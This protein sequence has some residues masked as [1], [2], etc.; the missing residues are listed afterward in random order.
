M[1]VTLPTAFSDPRSKT[2]HPLYHSGYQAILSLGVN[3]RRLEKA[4]G[5]QGPFLVAV[6]NGCRC[7]PVE[8]VG[9]LGVSMAAERPTQITFHRLVKR[10]DF[11]AVSRWHF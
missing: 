1:G 8:G 4:P 10:S 2:E 7:P 6:K 9:D 5:G 3:R 11:V